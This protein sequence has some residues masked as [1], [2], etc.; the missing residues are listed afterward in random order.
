[1]YLPGAPYA[2]AVRGDRLWV[3]LT[4]RDRLAELNLRRR[5]QLLALTPP[6]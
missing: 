6:R 1:V 5:P 2:I 3:T 4:A